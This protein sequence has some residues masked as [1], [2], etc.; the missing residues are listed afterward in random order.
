MTDL[1]RSPRSF[2]NSSSS[3][4]E[5]SSN[6]GGFSSSESDYSSRSESKSRSSS[7]CYSMKKLKP[8][9]TSITIDQPVRPRVIDT[10]GEDDNFRVNQV[11]RPSVHKHEGGV[12][13]AKSKAL[14]I[15]GEFKRVSGNNNKQPISPGGKLASFLNALFNAKK[16]KMSSGHGEN[17]PGKLPKSGH[18]STCSSASSF[19]RSCL[20]KTPSSRG[21]L[22]NDGTKR[23]VR[24]CPVS[25]IVDEDSRPCGQKS[26]LL[27][28]HQDPYLRPKSPVKEQE[29][30]YTV[31]SYPRMR[32]NQE[33]INDEDR[34]EEDD[35][36]GAS[37]ASSDL[38][39][40]ENLSGIGIGIGIGGYRYSEELPVY[41]TT[42]LDT[43]RAIANGLIV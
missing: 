21:K 38:F 35:D 11:I 8:I 27:G 14:K 6:K 26:V 12:V 9:R 7:S 25:V 10:L 5:S 16:A 32:Q 31:K 40:L 24:F 22:S 2:R 23:S 36:D 13:K 17:F 41:E 18:L 39:E 15:Y 4:S 1:Q 3:S 43:N 33:S 29:A 28:D 19:S 34:E 42:N 20:S 37:C 30:E